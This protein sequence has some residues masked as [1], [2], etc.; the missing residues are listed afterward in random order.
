MQVKDVMNAD[1]VTISPEKTIK[2]ASEMMLSHG[3]GSLVVINGTQL[4]G[5]ITERDIIRAVAKSK[6]KATTG[7]KISAV[8]STNVYLAKPNDDLEDIVALMQEKK[9]K[10]LPVVSGN[11][12]VGIV[13]ITDICRAEPKMIEALAAVMFLPKSKS[14]IAG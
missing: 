14:T 8:M 6:G 2:E 11:A 7:I 3:I 12:V 4:S 5:I 13:T 10:K 1:V 9:I